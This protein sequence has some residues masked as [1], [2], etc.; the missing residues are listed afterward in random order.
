MTRLMEDAQRLSQLE[1]RWNEGTRRCA[2][3]ITRLIQVP[4]SS[5]DQLKEMLHREDFQLT[6]SEVMRRDLFYQ[7]YLETS[8]EVRLKKRENVLAVI[9]YERDSAKQAV[10][11]VLASGIEVRPENDPVW[12]QRVNAKDADDWMKLDRLLKWNIQH[13]WNVHFPFDKPVEEENEDE[14]NEGDGDNDERVLGSIDEDEDVTEL[15]VTVEGAVAPPLERNRGESILGGESSFVSP[16]AVEESPS[17]PTSA[18]AET[19]PVKR[20]SMSSRFVSGLRLP[21]FSTKKVEKP[22][23]KVE[24]KPADEEPEKGISDATSSGPVSPPLTE[25]KSEP[26]KK[27][28]TNGTFR[29]MA[30]II[31]PEGRTVYGMFRLGTTSIV[32]EGQRII[33]EDDITPEKNVVLLKRRMYGIRVIKSVYRRRFRLDMMC[34]MEIYFVDGTSLLVG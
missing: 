4:I 19:E 13:V 11:I 6:E 22:T 26:K 8:Q 18:P 27:V 7:E 20:S 2:E 9:D 31:L 16:S 5:M 33:D 21:M 24:A 12:L 23:E 15:P 28:V 1:P 10:D 29:T 34:G 32:F 3:L 30:Y 25:E 14:V 17:T